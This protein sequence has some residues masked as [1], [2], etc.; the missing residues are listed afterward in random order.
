MRGVRLRLVVLVLLGFSVVREAFAEDRSEEVLR[1]EERGGAP[2]GV[3]GR[4]V[5]SD[6]RAARTARGDEH[7]L[8]RVR[9]M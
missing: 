8:G 4:V 7:D 9:A 1:L 2:P 3:G 5:G 6:A